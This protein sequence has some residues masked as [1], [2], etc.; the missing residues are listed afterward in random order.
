MMFF[1]KRMNRFAMERTSKAHYYIDPI[2][3]LSKLYQQE[4]KLQSEIDK[5]FVDILKD[6]VIPAK[7]IINDNNNDENKQKK[8]IDF[9]LDV[10]NGFSDVDIRDHFKATVYGVNLKIFLIF[11]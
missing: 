5:Y 9:L 3:R 6:E 7:T 1:F 11:Q 10:K 4:S 8:L 2:Y